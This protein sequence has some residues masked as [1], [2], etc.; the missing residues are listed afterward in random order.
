MSALQLYP[1]VVLAAPPNSP[2]LQVRNLS[3]GRV[4]V[5][6]VRPTIS[7]LATGYH[8]QP[9]VGDRLIIT[10]WSGTP[11]ALCGLSAWD[12]LIGSVP[13]GEPAEQFLYGPT[14]A[15]LRMVASGAIEVGAPATGFKRVVLD[16][17]PVS[18][19]VGG[20]GGGG[21][22]AASSTTLKGN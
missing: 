3:T 1:A 20:V 12:R 5:N 21:T 10:Y 2:F 18:V 15:V 13:I 19:T 11:I 9:A 22:V 4:L 14:G 17:D 8:W 6:V 7:G 16:G